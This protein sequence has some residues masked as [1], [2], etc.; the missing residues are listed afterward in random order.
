[1]IG[2]PIGG[3]A[4]RGGARDGAVGDRGSDQPAAGV[5]PCHAVSRD[6]CKTIAS[7]TGYDTRWRVLEGVLV[8]VS[9]TGRLRHMLISYVCVSKADGSKSLDLR[10]RSRND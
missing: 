10:R 6:V 9:Q 3:D 2:G 5:S 1:M 8:R 4:G 7:D